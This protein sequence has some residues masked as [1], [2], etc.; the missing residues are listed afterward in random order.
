VKREHDRLMEKF[1][2][3]AWVR[4]K[5][6]E[7]REK[8]VEDP[9]KWIEE[10]ERLFEPEKVRRA[11]VGE[12]VE[13]LIR[14]Y[15]LSEKSGKSNVIGFQLEKLGESFMREN[16]YVWKE[17]LKC[18]EEPK[19]VGNAVVS[20]IEECLPY[21]RDQSWREYVRYKKLEKLYKKDE[22]IEDAL[23][24]RIR[25]FTGTWGGKLRMAKIGM[26]IAFYEL[27]NKIK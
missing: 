2:N 26:K 21:M 23:G 18:P 14:K 16:R 6:D 15:L 1:G 9:E 24:E 11:G 5:I 19:A 13:I 4:K 12:L 3:Y 17:L 27:I 22:V 8:Y 7:I 10:A 25:Y 20:R